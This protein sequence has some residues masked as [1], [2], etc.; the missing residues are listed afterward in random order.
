MGVVVAHCYDNRLRT[1][2]FRVR[3]LVWVKSLTPEFAL[4]YHFYEMIITVTFTINNQV[5]VKHNTFRGRKCI[6]SDGPWPNPTR[7]Y[8][9]HAAN[10]MPTCL[11]PVYILTQSDEIFW[12]EGKNFIN[13]GF[14][15][16][17]FQI[18]RWLTWPVHQKN[19]P[20][21]VKNFRPGPITSK[22]H[23]LIILKWRKWWNTQ[24]I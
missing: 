16:E 15:G 6:V 14:L 4:I 5:T 20:T 12:T 22:I 2:R 19:S 7:A 11:H 17:I 3:S 13:V 23:I 24:V 9:L 18:H 21:K 1:G 10:K 8:I